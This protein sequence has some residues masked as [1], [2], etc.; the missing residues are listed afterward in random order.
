MNKEINSSSFFISKEVEKE[1]NCWLAK[2][3]SNQKRS[4]IVPALLFVQKQNGGWLSES[5]MNAVADYLELP[6]VW[7][8]EVATFYDMYNLKPIGKYKIGI[9]QNVSC[10]LR[11]S[12]EIVI[13]V[14]KRLGI[15][16]NET[17]PDGL[18]TLKSIECMAACGGAPICQID[19]RE[20]YE[21]LTPEK[22]LSIIDKLR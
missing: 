14:K 13:C 9:C 10:F 4:A 18:F 7:A 11:G 2:Y 6:R 3:P 1:I 12:D 15:D 17:T 19:D 22:I 21:N 20:Y 5:A 8:Y 16:F